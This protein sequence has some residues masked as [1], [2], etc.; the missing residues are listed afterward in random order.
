MEEGTGGGPLGTTLD[1]AP[2]MGPA[3]H[4]TDWDRTDWRFPELPTYCFIHFCYLH[5]SLQCPKSLLYVPSERQIKKLRISWQNVFGL[6]FC[7][8]F[9]NSSGHP[10]LSCGIA[11][12]FQNLKFAIGLFN[13]IIICNCET[14]T[15]LIFSPRCGSAHQ[16]SGN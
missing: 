9:T 16:S 15:S 13:S 14:I 10:D 4:L 6:T 11:L 7:D 5:V 2:T 3:P 12:K 8:C 1:R